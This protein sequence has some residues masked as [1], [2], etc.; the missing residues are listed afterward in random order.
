MR[1]AGPFLR[2][3]TWIGVA[4]AALLSWATTSPALAN[5]KATD[6]IE[7]AVSGFVRPA[8]AALHQTSDALDGVMKALCATPSAAGLDA[9]RQGFREELDA[10]SN[11]EIIRFGPITEQNRLERMLFWPDRKG[12]GLKQVQAAIAARDGSAADAAQLAGKSV[13]MQGL[14]A[15]EFVLFGTGA[16]A[17]SSAGDPYRCRYGAAIAANIAAI[18]ADTDAAWA[19]DDGFARQWANPE[20]DNALYQTGTEAVTELLEVFVN[21]LELVRDVRVGGFLGGTAAEDKPKQAIYWR[22]EG[23]ARS[24]AGN[25]SGM[26]ALFE[27][28]GLSSQLSSDMGWIGDS[29]R[30]EFGNAIAA[31]RAAEG[32]IAATLA[33]EKK[34]GKLA[35]FNVVTSSLSELFGKRLSAEFGLSAGFSSLDGD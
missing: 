1:R 21:G 34:R 4:V 16:E 32:P 25:I 2:Q 5:A 24:L 30:F 11:A 22:S 6:I 20:P 13:A 35:Y 17:L 23:T 14:G 33:D 8:Y 9:A 10:W 12:I 28:S 27:A 15:L 18:A 26:Q 29:I 3:S 31:A 19:D 7:H